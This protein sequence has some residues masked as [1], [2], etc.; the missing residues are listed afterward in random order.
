MP[1]VLVVDDDKDI[2]TA[3]RLLLRSHFDQVDT[4]S[5]PGSVLTTL[6]EGDYAIVMLDMNFTSGK[7]S[8]EEG[9]FWLQ[10][11]RESYPDL[12]VI[13]I[14]A[15]GDVD[16]AVRAI[17]QGATDFVLK[18]WHNQKVL[19]T[20]ASA[21]EL[22]KSRRQVE[23]LKQASQESQDAQ[24]GEI[25]GNSHEI[26][27]VLA[28]IERAAPTEANMLITGENGTGKEM[29]AREIHRRSSRADSVFVSIDLG[30]VPES[31]FESELFGHKK[32]SF[33]GAD[34]ER[35]G[36]MQ[37]ANGGTL[38]LDEIGNL[39]L[40]LQSKL[41]TALERRQ[42]IPVGGNQPTPIDIRLITATNMPYE[43]LTDESLFRQDLLF[44]I[45]TIE[46]SLPALRERVEDI[47]DLAIH[48]LNIYRRKYHKPDLRL[49]ASA[50][51]QL[52]RNSWRGNVREL[53]HAIERAIIL[54]DRSVL[55]AEDFAF[56]MP[57]GSES[58][59]QLNSCNLGEIER[60]AVE[61][62]LKK[63]QGNIS[64]ASQELGITRAAL[65]RRMEKH[66]I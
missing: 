54:C 38:F 23:Q 28:L 36:R 3:A 46:L 16:T 34:K 53:R 20:L 45:N 63:N 59:L 48:F 32:G 7:N 17:K 64:R 47:A 58:V 43:Q 30:A 21:M 62:A 14:T 13:M 18:P 65:Y 40:H 49:G 6:A 51:E 44:R 41:L 19:G 31:L 1:N 55:S 9:F 27:K 52:Q 15:F 29:V 24:S 25:R 12:V 35:I 5:D 11:I 26:R 56:S 66:G 39:P 61:Q 57:R 8:G 4:L 10:K 60:K 37:A 50:L 22:Y 2:L 42:V 33:T